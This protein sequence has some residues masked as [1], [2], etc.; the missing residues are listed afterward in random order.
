MIK[1]LI[2]IVLIVSF[3]IIRQFHKKS[4]YICH[5]SRKEKDNEKQVD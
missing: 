5:N 1:F 4:Y 3:I 2:G